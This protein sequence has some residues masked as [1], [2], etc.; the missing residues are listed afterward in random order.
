MRAN[1]I[2]ILLLALIFA[3]VLPLSYASPSMLPPFSI[4][5]A[6]SPPSSKPILNVTG[7]YWGPYIGQIYVT[8]FTT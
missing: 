6:P 1:I 8:W 5:G 7:E 2:Q 4:Y 3:S